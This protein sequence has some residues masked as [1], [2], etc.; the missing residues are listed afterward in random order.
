MAQAQKQVVPLTYLYTKSMLALVIHKEK[1]TYDF[2]L[3][4]IIFSSSAH[5]KRKSDYFWKTAKKS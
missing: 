4:R 1:K 5:K 2:Q 3:S